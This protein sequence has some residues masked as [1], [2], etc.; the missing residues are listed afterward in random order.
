MQKSGY[1][2]TIAIPTYN[3]RD[4]LKRALDSVIPQMSSDIE[5]LVS[6][7]A[8]N[9]GTEEMISEFFPMVRYIKNDVN[10]GYEG[11]FLMCCRQ[12]RGEYILVLGSDDRL[13]KGAVSYILNFLTKN[14]CDLIFMNFRRFDVTKNDAYI[15]N[16]EYIK[17]YNLYDDIITT[18]R[19]IF[20]KY[21]GHSISYISASIVKK[22][23]L[24]NVENPEKFIGTNFIHVYMIFEAVKPDSRFGIIFTPL[25]DAN[26][27]EGDSEISKKP[28]EF[29]TIFMKDL[30]DA[31]CIKAVSCGFDKEQM[32]KVYLD[33]L[34][35][36]S[37]LREII[38]QR[39]N[40][41]TNS[42][43]N[44]WED[45]YPI[46]KEYPAEK[47]KTVLVARFPLFLLKP[48]YKFYKYI[49]SKK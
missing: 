35:E 20:M 3:R 28:E 15:Q 40:G 1:K 13:A 30:H 24:A 14:N 22:S 21:A 9:D 16:S 7:N 46:L 17:N 27:T 43:K 33:F 37:V 36:R 42:I 29:F 49:K 8:S 19:S 38:V 6:D 25:L 11:N 48:I 32:H 12:S 39:V 31:L 5:V 26:T 45:G 23:T 18:D 4:L 41:N 2:L 34:R 10:L 47:I 44:F